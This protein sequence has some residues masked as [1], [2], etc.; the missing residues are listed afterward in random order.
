MTGFPA[1]AGSNGAS[2]VEGSPSALA[3]CL[4]AGLS[5]AVAYSTLEV[6]APDWPVES[7]VVVFPVT[8]PAVCSRVATFA[9]NPA[10]PLGLL[11]TA[12][13]TVDGMIVELEGEVDAGGEPVL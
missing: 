10:I 2:A 13:V 9:A 7:P 3:T 4:A 1:V 8:Y 5:A 6:V 11:S 12:T